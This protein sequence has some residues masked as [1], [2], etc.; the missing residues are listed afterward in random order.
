MIGFH[1]CY[2]TFAS[3][4]SCYEVVARMQWNCSHC[5]SE[6]EE[7]HCSLFTGKDT[8]ECISCAFADN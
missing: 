4:N 3:S 6:L 8:S 5:T 2:K 7:F 1:L